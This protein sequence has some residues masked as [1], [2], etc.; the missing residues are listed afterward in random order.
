MQ[1]QDKTKDRLIDEL[2]EMRRKVAEFEAVQKSLNEKELRYREIVD[3]TNEAIFVVQDGWIKYANEKT[4]E[5]TGYSREDA[6]ASAAIAAFVHPDDRE[7]VAQYHASRLQGDET[8]YRYTYRN[9]RKDGNVQ[10]V[11]M[12]SSLIMWKGRPASLCL[13]ADITERKRAEESM[14]ANE[15]LFRAMFERHMA[16]MLLIEPVTGRIINVNKAAERFYGYTKSHLVSMTIQDINALPPDEVEL[17]RN[18]AIKEERNHFIFPHRLASGEVRTVE[19]YSAPIEE[20]GNKLLFSIIHDVSDRKI[21]EDALKESEEKYRNLFNNS[22]VGMFR[23]RLDGSETLDVN[24]KFLKILNQTREEVVG[25]PAVILWADPH[26]REKIVSRINTDGQVNNFECGILT[27]QGEERTCLTSLKLYPDQGIVEGSIIDITER[28]RVEQALRDSEERY[29]ILFETAADGIF[30]LDAEGEN[31]GR[32]VAANPAAVVR[33]G[34]TADELMGLRISDLDTPESAEKFPG[35]LEQL[36]KGE[37]LRDEVKHRRKDGSVFSLEICDRLFVQSGHQYI[38][39]MHRDITERKRLEEEKQNLIIDL[40]KALSEVKKLSGFLPICASCKKIR[41][42][43]GYWKD[44]ERYIS[45][46]SEAEFTHGI[47]PDCMRK[48]YPEIADGIPGALEED[49]KK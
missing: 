6:L 25:K 35:R 15:E 2:N 29:R 5:L 34:Y 4:S 7:M 28:R 46:H 38:A 14:R 37:T 17:Q 42:D 44:V 41:D 24:D 48:L 10:W 45:E 27:A 12:N 26:E 3:K 43:K 39:A 23:S 21:A 32:I 22:G 18:L 36:L 13:M 8:H 9:V 11:E 20:N 16:V 1:D 40:Q 19:V 49:E 47:C 33:S 30:I 31:T